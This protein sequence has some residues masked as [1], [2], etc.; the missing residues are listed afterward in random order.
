MKINHLA[1]INILKLNPYQ[2]ARKLGGK[3]NIWLNAN[4]A[5]TSFTYINKNYNNL[6]RYPDCQPKTI[7]RN[8]A[9]YAG[10]QPDQIL[11]SRGAD[12][13]IE[14]LMRAFCE[15]NKD[16]IIFC[17]PTYGMYNICAETLGIKRHIIPSIA[18]TNWQLDLPAINL[19]LKNVKLIYICNPNNPTGNIINQYDIKKLL[20]L[21]NN[22]AL[23]IID[24]AYIDFCLHASLVSWLSK[25]SN[26]VIL[27]TLSKAFALAGLRC[28]FTIANAEIIKLL[29][30]V[31]TPYPLPSLVIDIAEQ[32]LTKKGLSQTNKR[33]NTINKNR[34]YLAQE[35]TKCPCIK[36]VFP[37]VSNY[38]LIKVY[39]Q[40]EV[41]KK[42]WNMGIIL[43]DQSKQLGLSNCIRI[44]IG[45]YQ[46]C[47]YVAN[48]LQQ[49]NTT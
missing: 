32:A 38:I 19:K 12:E 36:Q 44:T 13:G 24:E 9:S 31:I 35:L 45:T 48:I 23:L 10:V 4:E 1:R 18:N 5:P 11:V 26:L 27:R 29:L 14:L 20:H 49:L 8:Y 33:I 46:E 15:P 47:K 43:R 7:I 30:K 21:I 34:N 16:A 39:P 6:N 17:P 37:S 28:G 25:F 3:G 41:F 42:L 2:S 40:Y 22:R